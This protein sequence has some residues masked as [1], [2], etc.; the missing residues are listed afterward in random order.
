[1]QSTRHEGC[2]A[3][4][5][6]KFGVALMRVIAN[7]MPLNISG[8]NMIEILPLQISPQH[9]HSESLW[10][11]NECYKFYVSQ[12]K[13]N[14][15]F[16]ERM[17]LWLCAPYC[18]NCAQSD[19]FEYKN[20]PDIRSESWED[21]IQWALGEGT[22]EMLINELTDN[23][24]F[25]IRCKHCWCELRPWE[26]DNIHIVIYHLEE[27]Y[28]IPLETG[29]K[30]EPSQ[31][32]RKQITNLYDGKCF[33]CG[34]N[35]KELHIDHILPRSKGG[36]AAFRNL[37]PLCKKCGNLKAD[38]LP[39]EVEVFSDIYFGPHPSDGYEGLFW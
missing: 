33:G 6:A 35:T 5:R 9:K 20:D 18:E 31:K 39:N 21:D 29:N 8:T 37:Q 2:A 32:L 38:K 4:S 30:K 27:H 10:I 15:T 23:P 1:M 16:L 13:I 17:D 14:C 11:Q 25:T 34:K 3:L 26:N 24:N 12:R 7:V 28:G 19:P 22:F 36:D